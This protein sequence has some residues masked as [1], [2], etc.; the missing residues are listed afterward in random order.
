MEIFINGEKI[1]IGIK[2]T[3]LLNVLEKLEANVIQ[4]GE[5]IVEL[6]L[7]GEM[8]D[9]KSL[10]LNKKVTGFYLHHIDTNYVRSI[11]NLQ[12]FPKHLQRV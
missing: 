12:R 3:K 7:D 9:G 2:N 6:K 1:N 5:V 4:N 8:V 10:P 11:Y